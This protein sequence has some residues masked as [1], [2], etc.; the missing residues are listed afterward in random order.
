M[1][2]GHRGAVSK[3]KWRVLNVYV[4]PHKQHEFDIVIKYFFCLP[5]S[6]LE[7]LLPVDL[8]TGHPG[9]CSEQVAVT[10]TKYILG[11]L[12]AAGP[13]GSWNVLSWGTMWPCPSA[14]AQGGR[15]GLAARFGSFGSQH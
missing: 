14:A 13:C 3:Q 10:T 8:P 6:P 9:T 15:R 11:A 5:L 7:N 1:K 2:R 4:P 12:R